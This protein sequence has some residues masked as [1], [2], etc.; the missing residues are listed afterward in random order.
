MSLRYA[1][2][3]STL[4]ILVRLDGGNDAADNANLL[5]DQEADYFRITALFWNV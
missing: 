4:P 5:L 2:R 1:R 3:I